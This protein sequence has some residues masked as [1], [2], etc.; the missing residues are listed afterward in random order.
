[1][2]TSGTM[3]TTI[4]DATGIPAATVAVV[5]RFLREADLLPTGRPGV[6]ATAMTT[7]DAARTLIGLLVAADRP[8]KAPDA[9]RDFGAL[10][11]GGI[12]P[13]PIPATSVPEHAFTLSELPAQHRFDEA[14]AYVIG[15]YARMGKPLFL[16]V[17]VYV[18]E[19]RAEVE[20]LSHK[21]TYVYHRLLDLSV[22]KP[23][24]TPAEP[25]IVTSEDYSIWTEFDTVRKEYNNR[26]IHAQY[27][28]REDV[29]IPISA[30]FAGD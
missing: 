24:R 1:M 17:S 8:V 28:L 12:I 2:A 30:D 29:I 26:K 11:W 9:V 20:L 14:L 18:N 21:Y 23:N 25:S 6:H 5:V 16:R 22:E 15:K 27:M 19:L 4:A 10:Q 13:R 7:L 3:T